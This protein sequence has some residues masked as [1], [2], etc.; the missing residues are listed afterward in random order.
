MLSFFAHQKPVAIL[1]QVQ[2]YREET[3]D[4]HELKELAATAHVECKAVLT[5][6]RDRPD[7]QYFIGSGKADELADLL[8]HEAATLVIFNHDLTP[9]QERNLAQHLKV[10]VMSRTGLI[11]EIFA[12][13]ARTHEGKLQVELAQL[14]YQSSRLV[15]GWTH[16]ERQRGG[17]G[18]RG[19][20]G[21]T[22]LE[23][24]KRLLRTHIKSLKQQLEKV[25][26]TRKLGRALRQKA[27][28]P[29]I[30]LVGYTNAGKST[31]FNALT[32]SSV[33]VANQLFA[34]LDPT[35]RKINLPHF[36]EV[37]LADTVGFIRH[38]PHQLVKAFKA[39]L[40]EVVEADLLL[41]VIDASHPEYPE[42]KAQVLDVLAEMQVTETPILEVMNKVDAI[43]NQEPHT[44]LNAEGMPQR[45]WIS[46][47]TG[48]GMDGLK[49]AL[50]RCLDQDIFQ[51]HLLL[52]LSLAEIRSILYRWGAIEHESI[53][54]QGQFY[55]QLKA[56]RQRLETLF[57]QQGYD[58]QT[59]LA[60]FKP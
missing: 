27:D 9:T 35:L 40:E 46:A 38:L 37:V 26:R 43:E 14:E 54:E 34:T 59:F 47:L 51:G 32:E 21:E 60:S 17:I 48:A 13:R 20:P 7:A 41:H 6:T 2:F 23:I 52:P 31:L 36:G 49:A 16:L 57:K 50:L 45:A 15:R 22:Q 1:V 30:A 56:P 4:L 12:Q 44:D 28:I 3:P 53:D 25:E 29:C 58:Y 19:G 8:T 33:Y 18:V 10:Q 11:L 39:T 24:D 5:A 55:I 42:Q